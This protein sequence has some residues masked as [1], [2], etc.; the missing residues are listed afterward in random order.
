MDLALPPDFKDFLKLLNDHGVLYLLIGGYAVGYHGYPRA[1]NDM[2]VW[3]AVSAE[4]ARR[5]VTVLREFGFDSPELS[6]VPFEKEHSLVRMGNPPMRI[7][8]KTSIDG[9][10]FD[11]CYTT[12]VTDILDGTEVSLIDLAHLKTNKL[13]SGRRK[14][15]ADLDYLP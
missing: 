15:L 3:V 12:R 6:P 2:D 1:T 8:I 13:A 11:E 9:V 4:N 5:I 14:D 7:E 10:T